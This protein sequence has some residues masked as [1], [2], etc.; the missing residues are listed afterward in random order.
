MK[1]TTIVACA[2]ILTGLGTLTGCAKRHKI[3]IESNTCWIG[4]LD[5]Q[6]AEPLSACGSANYRIAGDISC[7]AVT[8]LSDTGFVRVRI[9]DGPWYTANTPR[10]TTEA[11]R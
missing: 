8:L 5:K 11:C 9:D 10:G 4:V 6:R 1:P 2:L 7:I 3:A